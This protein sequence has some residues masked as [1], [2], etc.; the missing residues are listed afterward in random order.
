M[1]FQLKERENCE[2]KKKNEEKRRRAKHAR[3]NEAAHDRA[4]NKIYLTGQTKRRSA[5][6]AVSSGHRNG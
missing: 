6:D 5:A 4:P 3:Q 2:E 1:N